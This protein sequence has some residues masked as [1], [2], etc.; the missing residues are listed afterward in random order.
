MKLTLAR[1]KDGASSSHSA[2][3]L[4]NLQF[5]IALHYQLAKQTNAITDMSQLQQLCT[6]RNELG[7]QN[8]CHTHTHTH[9]RR[10]LSWFYSV[11]G[12][13]YLYVKH[14]PMTVAKLLQR[15]I[16]VRAHSYKHET[17]SPDPRSLVINTEHLGSELTR[18]TDLKRYYLKTKFLG[19]LQ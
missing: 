18:L 19:L 12:G 16:P 7:Q 9:T 15:S 13:K 8:K 3:V 2:V 10:R 17:N 14:P 1:T 6:T 11:P 4:P 5:V